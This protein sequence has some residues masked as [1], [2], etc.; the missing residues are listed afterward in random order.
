MQSPI[1]Y[2]KSQDFTISS[3]IQI[4]CSHIISIT[5]KWII[6][7]CTSFN[8]SSQLSV[9]ESLIK[10]TQNELYIPSKTLSYG[11]YEFI[12]IVSINAL[13]QLNVSV[14][15]FIE[16]I[17]SNIIVNFN[18]YELTTITYGYEQDL[19]FNPGKYSI[20]P[21]EMI[22]D[23]SAWTYEYYCRIYQ[24]SLLLRI[25][26]LT[27][28]S[29]LSNSTINK[30][31]FGNLTSSLIIPGN[32]LQINQT[33]QFLIKII[34]HSNFSIQ[35]NSSL[36]VTIIEMNLPL[37]PIGCIISTMC[38]RNFDYQLV[39]PSTQIALYS[40]CIGNCSHIENITWN[41]YQGFVNESTN[42]TQWILLN[43]MISFDNIWF[44]GRHRMNFTSTNQLF[45]AHPQINHWRFEVVYSLSFGISSSFINFLINQPPS[46]GSCFIY[47]QTGTTITV[48]T[49]NC[50]NWY[51]KYGIKDYSLYSMSNICV[52]IL[53]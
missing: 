53:M 43:Q 32:S 30:L 11:I 35:F 21:D 17:S 37:I 13:S 22:F 8:C 20:N 9:N 5:N 14:S 2:R 6:K 4:N 44:F 16:I 1:L 28:S 26:D 27:N 49:I 23:A 51:D 41:I 46:N 15:S 31:I 3:I 36:T 25:D 38:I 52:Y 33:Y 45:L 40:Y 48:F 19:I 7:S 10:T 42:E 29:C 39:N 47:P 50:S 12:L 18:E 34:H 24:S